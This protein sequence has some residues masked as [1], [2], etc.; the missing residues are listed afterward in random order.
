MGNGLLSSFSLSASELGAEEVKASEKPEAGG[1][2]QMMRAHFTRETGL[3]ESEDTEIKAAPLLGHLAYM[4]VMPVGWE[5]EPV[6]TSHL[7]VQQK[8]VER[9][10]RARYQA[11][12]WGYDRKQNQ[13]G[14][15]SH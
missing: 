5:K 2:L 12:R 14:P 7:L 15:G 9:R 10:I 1:A 8:C 3:K 11:I 13:C 6:F 4:M